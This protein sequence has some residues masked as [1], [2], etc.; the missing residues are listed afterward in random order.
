MS[1]LRSLIDGNEREVARL[2]RRVEG[3]NVLEPEFEKLSD[4]QLRAKTDEFRKRVAPQVQRV[5][6][7]RAARMAAKEPAEQEAA[8]AEVKAAYAALDGALTEILPE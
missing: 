6:E 2:R 3:I 4:E 5:D 8:D 1:W 7:A